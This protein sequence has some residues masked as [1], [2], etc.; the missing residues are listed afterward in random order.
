[1]N[2][3]DLRVA[4][5]GRLKEVFRQ[6]A[7]GASMS[8]KALSF[9]L[10]AASAARFELHPSLMPRERQRPRKAA[11]HAWNDPQAAGS[12]VLEERLLGAGGSL[13]LR[14][15][16]QP[17]SRLTGTE[18]ELAT[19]AA[20]LLKTSHKAADRV[21]AIPRRMPMSEKR[22]FSARLRS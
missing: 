19:A 11:L 15:E 14:L 16:G 2:P 3:P 22:E 5:I 10:K 1:V 8:R 20:L 13:T 18:L 6:K 9:Y 12:V 21:S 17:F 4:T 7:T